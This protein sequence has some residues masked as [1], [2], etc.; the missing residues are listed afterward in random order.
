MRILAAFDGSPYSEAALQLAARLAKS[1]RAHLTVLIVAEP[2][3]PTRG[4]EERAK[5]IV[6]SNGLQAEVVVRRVPHTLQSPASTIVEEAERGG[7]NMI[8]LGAKGVSGRE[9]SNIGST[10]LWVVVSSPVSV[11]VVR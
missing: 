8:V 1:M 9:E 7:Y 5:R 11:L 6:E 2:G 3:Q 10:A 4:L